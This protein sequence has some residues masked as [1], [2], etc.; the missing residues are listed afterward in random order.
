MRR[1]IRNQDLGIKLNMLVLF[2][3]SIFLVSIVY[4]L[5][6]NTQRLTDQVGDE[7]IMEEVNILENRLAELE[8]RMLVDIN[9]L[10]GSVLFFQAVGSRNEERVAEIVNTTNLLLK[11]DD[12]S[13][14]DG[15]GNRLIDTERDQDPT[16]EDKLLA[17]GLAGQET[18]RLLIESKEGEVQVSI[19]AVAPIVNTTGNI[20]GAIQM[21]RLMDDDFLRTLTFG[22]EAVHLGLIYDNHIIARTNLSAERR[23]T[24]NVL[25]NGIDADPTPLSVARDG[26]TV[27]LDKL[28]SGDKGVPHAGAYAPIRTDMDTTPA[29]VMILVE[30]EDIHSFQKNTLNNTVLIFTALTLLAISTIYIAIHRTTIRPLNQLKA[31]AQT[32]TSGQ[33]DERAPVTSHDEVG[34]LAIAFNEMATAIQQREISL[35][36]AREQAEQADRVKSMFLANVSHELRTPLNAI[37][38]LT[39]FVALGMYGDVNDEQKETLHKVEASGK[40][41]LNLI[42]NVLDISKIESGSLELFVEDGVNIEEIIRLAIETAKGLLIQKPV[43][44]RS[45]IAPDLPLMTGDQQRIRQ[46]VLNLLSNAC[47]FTDEGE[48][49]VRADCQNGEV[50]ICVRDTGPGIDPKE[51]DIIFQVFRQAKAGVRKAEGTGLGLPI[52]RR[53]AE[54]HGGRLWVNS[55]PGEGASFYIA[56]PVESSLEVTV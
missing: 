15:D 1:L 19:A 38:N 28:L 6:R 21:S 45:D 20:L 56:L 40:H 50:T 8:D 26:Q 42:N 46:I 55:V 41:L 27:V 24:Q 13:V 53:L 34:Q 11:L 3:L 22:R 51:Q 23:E 29:V 49:V 14:V 33:Y 16:E 35:K 54:A 18:I 2:V 10:T 52:S 31:I 17:L 30:L 12:I 9:F 25:A 37:I 48:I 32:M 5:N 7:R 44:I 43:V 39:K 4:L 36:E 47:K